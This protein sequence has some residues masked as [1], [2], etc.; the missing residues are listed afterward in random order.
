[1]NKVPDLRFLIL[2]NISTTDRT[3]DLEQDNNPL[4]GTMSPGVQQWGSFT[5]NANDIIMWDGTQWSVIFNSQAQAGPT[6]ITNKY[7]GIQ[8]KWEG[9]SWTKSMEGVY[10]AGKWQVIL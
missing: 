1:M 6:F 3:Y 5:A 4:T 2:E 9:E 8:Y 10:P 7:T